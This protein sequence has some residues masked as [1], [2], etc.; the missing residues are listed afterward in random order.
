MKFY[1]LCVT[2]FFLLFSCG[3]KKG[4]TNFLD[5]RLP[6]SKKIAW[7]LKEENASLT[8][9]PDEALTFLRKFYVSRNNKALWV[10]DSAFN[11]TGEYVYEIL[12]DP[13]ALGIPDRRIKIPKKDT[14]ISIIIK[15]LYITN[16]LATLSRDLRYGILD[17]TRRKNKSLSYPAVHGFQ[18]KL[19]FR[20]DSLEL[21][22][23]QIMNWGPAD[24][25][26]RKLAHR[27]FDFVRHHNVPGDHNLKVPVYKKNPTQSLNLAKK[28]LVL[29]GY[30][31]EKDKDSNFHHALKEFQLDNGLKADGLLGQT[32]ADALN[33]TLLEKCRRTAVVMEKIR[34]R[35]R[36]GKRYIEVN[37]PEYTLRFFAD[38]TLKSVNRI[39]V[40]KYDT[41]TPEFDAEL[42]TIISYPYWRVP[43]SI[44]S[45]EILP[46]ARRDS[47]YFAKNNMKLYKKGNEINPM[48]VN[49]KNISAKSFPYTVVQQPGHDNSLGI[50][51]FDFQNKYGVYFH[52]TPQKRLFNTVLR[53]Y[54]HGCMRCENP[55]ELAK[56]ILV[57][58]KNRMVPDS[59]DS[60]LARGIHRTIHLKKRIPIYVEYHS[61]VVTPQRL[62]F[63]RDIYL[64]DRKLAKVMF[65]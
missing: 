32:T 44:A 50:I 23:Q 56:M 7:I 18:K 11:R 8:G 19:E 21:V 28:S 33:E 61:V 3:D 63:L 59:L 45:K 55:V 24:T 30:L 47:L 42:R 64:R 1:M 43:F 6:A 16:S 2:F 5:L 41:Q 12:R 48:A 60:L 51:K 17:S 54:S 34:W 10:K 14:I 53:S 52:D 22:A 27:L 31:T 29:K 39:I 46:D 15:E 40:G 37:I 26:Y 65:G 25:V 49:W 38:D 4:E 35:Q 9:L 57:K 62:V 13:L 58:D 36:P 20:S